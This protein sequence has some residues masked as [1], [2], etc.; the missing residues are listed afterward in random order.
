MQEQ[1]CQ[2]RPTNSSSR[3]QLEG[4]ACEK[5]EKHWYMC[6]VSGH[7]FLLVYCLLMI[8]EE[9]R[10]YVNFESVQQSAGK[11]G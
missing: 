5:A 7:A 1:F 3:Q 10:V 11:Q 6:H 4:I 2:C 8:S 9:L